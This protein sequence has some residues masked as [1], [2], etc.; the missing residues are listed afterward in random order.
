MTQQVGTRCFVGLVRRPR[1]TMPRPRRDRTRFEQ[2]RPSPPRDLRPRPQCW[3]KASHL[4][5]TRRL[6][7]LA[8]A[9][10]LRGRL[11]RLVRAVGWRVRGCRCRFGAPRWPPPPLLPSLSPRR[12]TRPPCRAA[13]KATSL[14]QR[15][16]GRRWGENMLAVTM[17]RGKADVDSG[18]WTMLLFSELGRHPPAPRWLPWQTRALVGQR[19]DPHSISSSHPCLDRR[20]RR[21]RPER[22]RAR[23]SQPQLRHPH[24]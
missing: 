1:C 3:A 17:V 13:Q 10:G 9:L 20:P 22:Q 15:G 24:H 8:P 5:R 6:F 4:S 14:K 23:P 12:H 21:E 2:P 11:R 16:K 7:P 18:L 19:V